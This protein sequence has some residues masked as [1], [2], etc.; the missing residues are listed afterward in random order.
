[1]CEVIALRRKDESDD[2]AQNK[3]EDEDGSARLRLLYTRAC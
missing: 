1:V 2:G 3:G